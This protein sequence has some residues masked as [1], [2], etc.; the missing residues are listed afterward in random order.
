[1]RLLFVV[2][3][4]ALNSVYLFLSILLT[5][6]STAS[7]SPILTF[8]PIKDTA[9]FNGK[10][11]SRAEIESM[12]RTAISNPTPVSNLEQFRHLANGMFQSDGSLSARMSG[13]SIRPTFTL[14]QNMYPGSLVF[15]SQLYHQLGGLVNLSAVIT[16]SNT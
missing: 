8:D 9:L 3:I 15:F 13:I 14:V 7:R 1:M 11:I 6:T 10:L 2:Y 5:K 16:N 4:S 12:I